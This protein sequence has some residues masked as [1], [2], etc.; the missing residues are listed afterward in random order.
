MDAFN[1][2]VLTIAIILL[3][4]SLIFIGMSLYATQ[5]DALWP[6]DPSECPDYWNIT[7]DGCEP[8]S[9]LGK[10]NNSGTGACSSR[11]PLKSRGEAARR[12]ACN[13]AKSCGVY[14]DGIS[15]LF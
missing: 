2:T 9:S 5:S 11:K 1:K 10:H 4:I 14:W 8:N 13:W 15:K 6:P 12:K 3:V 7:E